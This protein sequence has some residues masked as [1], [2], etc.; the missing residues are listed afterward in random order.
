MTDT[1]AAQSTLGRSPNLRPAWS[2]DARQSALRIGHR[3]ELISGGDELLNIPTLTLGVG[4]GRTLTA[5]IDF[6]SNSEIVPDKTGGNETQLW[7]SAPLRRRRGLDAELT[8][9]WNSAA[10]SADGALSVQG[11]AGRASLVG[12]L[13]GF[14]SALGTGEAGVAVAAGAVVT[15]TRY[16]ELSGDVGRLLGHDTLGTVWSAG[17]AMAIPGSPH[18]LALQVTNGGA[19][20]LQ[21]AS[22]PKVLGPE[23]LR[24]GFVFTV[25]LGSR[26]QWGQIFKSDTAAAPIDAAAT[27]D[28]RMVA[29]SPREVRIR[30]GEQ[31]AW[32]NHDPLMHTVTANDRS[33]GS[34]PLEAGASFVHRFDRP[35]RFTYH[36]I[37]HPQMTGV[38]IVDP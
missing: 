20:T 24:Y 9:A 34:G 33:W 11:R 37:P 29:I 30:A 31:V 8:V 32:I 28:L 5:G 10:R 4:L 3:F 14:S 19:T 13:R 1:A 12:E 38:V 21:G 23:S 6:T 15:L 27:V 16:L 25:P 2:T 18:T 26:R 17:M 22:R 36:C 35:G 7:L